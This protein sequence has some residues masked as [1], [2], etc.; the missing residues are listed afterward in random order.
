[1]KINFNAGPSIL[2]QAVKKQLA[3]SIINLEGKGISLLE[4]SHRSTL[5]YNI[6]DELIEKTRVLLNI[7]STHEVLYL[8]GGGRLQFAQIPMNFL[9]KNNT[10]AFINTGYWANKACQYARNYGNAEIVFS[11][12]KFQYHSLEE[13]ST[14]SFL[15]PQNKFTYLQCT[16]NNTIYGTQLHTFPRTNVPLICD[17]S[18]DIFS[19]PISFSD[20]SLCF[21]CAQK[22]IAPA[23]LS[24]VIIH[25]DFLKNIKT[26]IPP[27]FNY[28]HLIQNQSAYNTPP[29][30][31][32]YAALLTLRWLETQG[33][34]ANIEKKNTARA[35]LLYNE[36][37]RNSLFTLP[38]RKEDRSN[39][40]ICFNAIS[41]NIQSA[42][43]DY[44]TQQNI[45][46]LEG[47]STIG[48]F[49]ASNYNAQ[50]NENI[51]YLIGVMQQAEK[52][53]SF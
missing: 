35:Q 2:P 8:Q 27:V 50:T 45:V 37:E 10:A 47:H 40:N 16:S 41:E 31:N 4:L 1:M 52:I 22:N 25:N 13:L 23:G 49:R 14:C 12:E 51:Y 34:I 53:I 32:M 18:S 15:Y 11:A 21:A 24:L 29:I 43:L 39:M 48:G 44:C 3:E 6:R 38:V 30:F 17:M 36:I 28:Q 42:F 26:N 5:F 7:P 33:G 46:G 9:N 20:F 19:R